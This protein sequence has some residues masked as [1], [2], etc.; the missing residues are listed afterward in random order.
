MGAQLVKEAA[1]KTTDAAGDGTT[2]AT[3]LAEAIFRE[4]LKM[5]AAGHD[6]MALSRG[7]A[8]AVEA[9]V[10]QIK[11]MARPVK[12]AE[13]A[14]T[15]TMSP[16]SPPTT[17]SRIGKMLAEAFEKVGKDGVIT[18]E[19]G[20]RGLETTLEVVEGMQFD[21]G[22]LSP[23][24]IT[25][26]DAMEVELDKAFVL[27]HEDKISSVQKLVPLLEKVA[28]A[29]RPLFIIAEDVEGEALATLVVNKL[30]GIVSVCAVKAP[31]YGDRRKAMLEDI[32][33]LTGGQAV[34][35]DLG[36]A[37]KGCPQGPRPGQEGHDRRR[38]HH[39]R[40]RRAGSTKAIQARIA[41]IRQRDREHRQRL[42]PREAPGAPRQAGRWRRPDQRGRRDRDRDEGK[43]GPHRGRPACDPRRPGGG[44]RGRWRRGSGAEHRRA[45]QAEGVGR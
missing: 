35:K 13:Q 7:I 1:S 44:H 26:G 33:V 9:I 8:K 12:A 5:I 29:K 41:Q 14:T 17:T 43:E 10:E 39:D 16:P 31:G 4:G 30:R 18:V 3:V 38:E 25:N 15:S 28:K 45:R 23:H 19:E 27:I 36:V 21:R 34:M 32:A 6:P 20:K 40:R 37:G 2:T 24:F 11:S 42:R 22:Y